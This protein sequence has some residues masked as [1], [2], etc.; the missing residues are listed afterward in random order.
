MTEVLG[1]AVLVAATMATG[2]LAGLFYAFAMSV[3]PGLRGAGDRTFVEAM[4]RINVAIVNPWLFLALLGAP[5]LSLAAAGLMLGG[6]GRGALGWTVAGFVLCVATLA[7]TGAA[8]VP[9]NNALDAAGPPER[10]V[11]PAKARRDF[12]A[13]WVR[14]NTVRAVTSAA[15]FGCLAW[16][17]VLHGQGLAG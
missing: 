1:G 2:L 3:M 6:G 11:D 17:L 7:V 8:N 9:L 13:G 10:I 5:V 14:W 4:Q 15:A 12:E 16:A